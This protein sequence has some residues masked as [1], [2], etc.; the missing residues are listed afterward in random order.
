[1]TARFSPRFHDDIPHMTLREYVDLVQELLRVRLD[2][3]PDVVERATDELEAGVEQAESRLAVLG[4]AYD[5][6]AELRE[7]EFESQTDKLAGMV[8][9]CVGYASIVMDPGLHAFL[10]EGLELD[11][12]KRRE[13][14][15]EHEQAMQSRL[16]LEGL[17][18]EDAHEYFRTSYIERS[19][20]LSAILRTLS[21]GELGADVQA[22]IQEP[23][24]SH[25]ETFSAQYDQHASQYMRGRDA[26]TSLS[27]QHGML[28]F[29]IANYIYEVG[30]T[31]D[32]WSKES[33]DRVNT[34][35]WPLVECC[36]RMARKH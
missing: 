2:D 12:E 13:R 20:A 25:A 27:E 32:R 22:I 35:I 11:A 8:R 14:E 29:A 1:V 18:G 36:Q 26:A 31:A 17:F 10:D 4:S 24:R 23:L 16:L 6:T 33:C 30:Q 21:G 28:R 15:R 9:S 19:R 5:P 7:L 34:A 3:M